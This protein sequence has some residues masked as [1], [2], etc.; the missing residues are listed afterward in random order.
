VCI[1]CVCLAAPLSLA[2]ANAYRCAVC[3]GRLEGHVSLRIAGR[4]TC[5]PWVNNCGIS[6]L[7]CSFAFGHLVQRG[8]QGCVPHCGTP[9]ESGTAGVTAPCL[10]P[11]VQTVCTGTCLQASRVHQATARSLIVCMLAAGAAYP[12]ILQ[13]ISSIMCSWYLALL[14]SLM[15]VGLVGWDGTVFPCRA[16]DGAGAVRGSTLASR[17]SCVCGCRLMIANRAECSS[18]KRQPPRGTACARGAPV[19]PVLLARGRGSACRG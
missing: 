10:H 15:Y 7:S 6:L 11:P 13:Q 16:V 17:S 4:T 3:A 14:H 12:P 8:G 5:Q 2:E 19:A 9:G 18:H 1:A